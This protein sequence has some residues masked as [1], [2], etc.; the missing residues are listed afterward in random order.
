MA[1]E[2]KT[3]DDLEKTIKEAEDLKEKPEDEDEPVVEPEEHEELDEGAEDSPE[4]DD[5]EDDDEEEQ[6]D[7]GDLLKEVDKKED[8]KKRHA[9]STKE[10]QKIRARTRIVDKAID[11]DI[12][13]PTNEEM[14]V[15]FPNWED[16][17]E[18]MQQL[19][20]ESTM[21]KKFREN[22]KKARLEGKRIDNWNE[23]VIEYVKDPET[24]VKNPD[25]EGRQEEFMV[26]ATSD[27]H[28]D[29]DFDLLVPAFLHNSK[30]PTK[31]KGAMFPTGNAGEK[32]KQKPSKLTVE[33]GRKLR[34]TD[35]SK[36]KRYLTAGKIESI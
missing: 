30:A 29:I 1:E 26:F 34:E 21:N 10:N 35:Y 17:D 28:I 22:L 12:P 5:E 19:A 7:F 23:K 14:M 9:E 16:M 20:K 6:E 8:Y 36:W 18:N 31:N 15:E 2:K 13:E 24:L 32:G 3:T 33:Q 25:L 27:S 11:E 4:A